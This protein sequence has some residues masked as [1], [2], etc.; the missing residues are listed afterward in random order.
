VQAEGAASL[1]ASLERGEVVERDSV[2]TIADGIATR[3]V[4]DRPFEVIRERVDEVITVSD[5]EIA[6]AMTALLERSKVLAEGAG[7]AGVAALLAG[8]FDVGTDEQVVAPICGGNVDPNV[9]A[10]V[11]MRGLVRSGRYLRL[12]TVLKDRP[13]ALRD[14]AALIAEHRANVH[15][16]QHDRT[17][18]DV[19]MSSAEVKLDL[20]TRGH[21]HV[22][23]IVDA[24]Q[25]R[26]YPVEVLTG[27]AVDD[28]DPPAPARP[29]DGR[30]RGD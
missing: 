8:A 14:L 4:G 22:A 20:E 5:E 9:L 27:A 2:E 21:D 13:G 29:A 1:P 24:L 12:R 6:R 10:T 17:A 15:A 23:T 11:L 3:R 26:G 7:A 30:D 25:Q 28:A 19:G 16:I 18:R